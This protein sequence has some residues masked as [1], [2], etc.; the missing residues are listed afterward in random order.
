MKDL[1]HSLIIPCSSKQWCKPFLFFERLVLL[2]TINVI[3]EI[4]MD[5]ALKMLIFL[6]LS[7]IHCRWKKKSNAATEEVIFFFFEI[8]L[9]KFQLY[10]S[11]S[12]TQVL[13]TKKIVTLRNKRFTFSVFVIIKYSLPDCSSI[14]YLQKQ[15]QLLHLFFLLSTIIWS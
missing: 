12:C 2:E 10:T 14:A 6:M 15:T 3:D 5:L 4:V 8:I 9:Y 1:A 13:Y 7:T 11:S